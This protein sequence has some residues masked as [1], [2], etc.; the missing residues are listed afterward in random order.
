VTGLPRFRFPASARQTGRARCRASGFPQASTVMR[1][2]MQLPLDTEYPRLRIY[3][4]R[5]RGVVI[6]RHYSSP[7]LVLLTCCPP[8]P[9][10]RLSRPR[11]VGSEVARL[12]ANHRPPLKLH[13][14]F[15]RM[16]LS[17]RLSS[18][19]TQGMGLTESS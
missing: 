1:P 5:P 2:L 17:Q 4:A 10:G 19:E 15:C 13:V 3:D 6:Q 11:T 7:P 8:S 9:C 14:R 16:Q 18:T 12:R